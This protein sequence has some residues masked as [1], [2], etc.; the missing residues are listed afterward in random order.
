LGVNDIY[1]A[2]HP[3]MGDDVIELIMPPYIK[4]RVLFDRLLHT[5]KGHTKIMVS[6]NGIQAVI[7]ML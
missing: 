7:L 3:G 1:N 6:L 5:V 2:I 4:K